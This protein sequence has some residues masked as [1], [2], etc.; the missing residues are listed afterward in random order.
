MQL[1]IDRLCHRTT[2][3]M[4]IYH[5]VEYL[6]IYGTRSLSVVKLEHTFSTLVVFPADGGDI[7]RLPGHRDMT[8]G[9]IDTVDWDAYSSTALLGNDAGFSE[10]QLSRFCSRRFLNIRVTILLYHIMHTK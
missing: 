5:A 4:T 2:S 3:G 10:F 7:A 9:A 6:D 1:S 8:I